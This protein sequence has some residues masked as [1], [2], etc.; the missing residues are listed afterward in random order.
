MPAPMPMLRGLDRVLTWLALAVG[1]ATLVFMTVLSTVNVLVMRKALNDPIR[2][3]EDLMVLA[4][5][6]VVAVSIPY[7]A[8]TGAHIEIELLDEYLPRRLR[9]VTLPLV[10]VLAIVIVSLLSW[11]LWLAGGSAS[12][13]GEAS[14]ELVISFG[15]F[16]RILAAASAVYAFVLV[17]EL[18][19]MLRGRPL[20]RIE[21]QRADTPDIADGGTTGGAP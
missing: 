18:I 19:A 6:L 10:K 12:R 8:R 3:A 14:R 16:Y 5:V 11:Q 21:L 9:A 2:G 7:G 17:L 1:G 4:L 15:P 20:A 13:F